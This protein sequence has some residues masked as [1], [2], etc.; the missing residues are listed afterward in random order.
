MELGIILTI[1]SGYT[2]AIVK[3]SLVD[4]GYSQINT[5]YYY[6]SSRGA[7]L[8]SGLDASAADIIIGTAVGFIP[9][10]GPYILW[11]WL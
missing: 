10:I 6:T 1:P 11:G 8:V 7:Q 9:T 3:T 2:N 5:R 4:I